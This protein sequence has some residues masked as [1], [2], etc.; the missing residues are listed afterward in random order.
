[1][2][3]YS[4]K[5]ATAEGKSWQREGH[6]R[7]RRHGSHQGERQVTAENMESTEKDPKTSFIQ[8]MRL[9]STCCSLGRLLPPPPL[10]LLVVLLLAVLVVLG[11][12]PLLVLLRLLPLVVVVAAAPPT[13]ALVFPV[14]VLVLVDKAYQ[15]CK[16]TGQERM[17]VVDELTPLVWV[18]RGDGGLG[19]EM[20]P[21]CGG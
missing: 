19:R 21:V 3:H 7:H 18:D 2:T 20:G 1:M 8:T 13:P 10:L 5:K 6:G 17:D 9:E 11:L 16:N 15:E 12:L 14:I 4:R